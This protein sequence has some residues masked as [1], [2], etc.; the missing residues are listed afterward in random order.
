[1]SHLNPEAL[2]AQAIALV[3]AGQRGSARRLCAQA[4][5]VFPPHPSVL[6]LLALLDLQDGRVAE[7]AR[8]AEA[9]LALRPAHPHTQQLAGEAF[10]Q[11]SLQRHEAGDRGG[12]IEALQQVVKWMPQRAEAFVNL[13]IA[14]QE[15]GRLDE[16]M[17][18]YGRAW[19]LRPEETFG[20]IA[21]A[22]ATPNSGRMWL[23]LDDLR[24]ALAA[25]SA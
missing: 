23:K 3:N 10:F 13:G 18:A 12:E 17:Q 25:A 22:L 14:L 16:A 5:G 2:M 15:C 19:R 21:H 24:A 11:L 8:S 6:Q 7:A 9:S 20:R 4:Q 1:M